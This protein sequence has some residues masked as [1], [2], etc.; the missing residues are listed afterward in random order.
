MPLKLLLVQLDEDAKVIFG[1]VIDENMK[2]EL[3]ITV[4][5]TDLMMKE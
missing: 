2:D 5:A 3:R 4:V 1:T